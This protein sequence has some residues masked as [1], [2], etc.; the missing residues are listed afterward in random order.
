[1]ELSRRFVSCQI[2][3]IFSTLHRNFSYSPV[4]YK[5]KRLTKLASKLQKKLLRAK[6]KAVL[7][8]KHMRGS[9]TSATIDKSPERR[10][11]KESKRRSSGNSGYNM[12]K[13]SR[14]RLGTTKLV[15]LENSSTKQPFERSQSVSKHANRI[16]GATNPVMRS[17]RNPRGVKLPLEDIIEP[18]G[19][20]V[21]S[22]FYGYGMSCTEDQEYDS[23]T[24]QRSIRKVLDLL[25]N[26]EI[27]RE[28]A[29]EENL[30]GVIYDKSETSF[31]EYCTR[32]DIMDELLK[33]TLKDIEEQ[34]HSV[35][36]MIPYF[37][38]HAKK[39][40]PHL[41]C[42]RELKQKSDL[43]QIHNWYPTARAIHR[44]IIFHAGPTNSGKTYE[45]LERFKEAKSG[46]YCAPLRLL[47]AEIY[48]KVNEAGVPCDLLTGEDRRFA[49]ENGEPAAHIA[50][51]V[52]VN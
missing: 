44:K 49:N 18:R 17:R 52:W 32:P 24:S 10:S 34:G 50:S 26:K 7:P 23:V 1:M 51:T 40:F 4:C 41:E 6:S 36:L 9:I 37:F 43:T 8:N 22:D 39:I 11:K 35:D 30:T 28:L 15:I 38:A 2:S 5:S 19:L 27:V 3:T 21:F 45:A 46:S 47:A 16:F 42:L 29:K 20:S 31:R 33:I 25:F 14:E 12:A 13:F 48:R